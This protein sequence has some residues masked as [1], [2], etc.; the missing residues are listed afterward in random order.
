MKTSKTREQRNQS[1]MFLALAIVSWAIILAVIIAYLTT[2]TAEGTSDPVAAEPPIE[3]R[4]PARDEVEDVPAAEAAYDP[5][6]EDIPM[7]AEHQRLLYRACEE[8]GIRYE[9]ALAVIWKETDFRNISG[10]GGDSAGYMQVQE[11]F[12]QDRMDKY[13]IT[14]LNDPYSNFLVGCDYLAEMIGEEKGLEWALMAYN[15]GPSYANRMADKG[16]VS[17]YAREVI[18]SFEN[19]GGRLPF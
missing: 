14:D 16:I 15:G 19:L 1:K 4:E 17:E 18:D 8:T 6:R 11:R 5:V 10:D 12:H 13:G 7:D 3:T 2:L 9:L